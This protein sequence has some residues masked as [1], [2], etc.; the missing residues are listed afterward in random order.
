MQTIKTGKARG[1][2]ALTAAA[3]ALD[4][5]ER[6]V[7]TAVR[8]YAA[9]PEDIDERLR[10]NVDEADAAEAAWKRERAALA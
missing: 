2:A 7:R 4:L 9:Y 1:D 3:D 6:H 8:Y 5:T 10:R